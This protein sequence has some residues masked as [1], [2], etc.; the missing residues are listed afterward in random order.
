MIALGS[1]PPFIKGNVEFRKIR[2]LPFYRMHITAP[3]VMDKDPDEDTLSMINTADELLTAAS[4][5]D[6]QEK[7]HKALSMSR[8]LTQL[9]NIKRNQKDLIKL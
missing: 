3:I 9:Y 7:R 5:T 8:W 4:E 1:G 2:G 6:D